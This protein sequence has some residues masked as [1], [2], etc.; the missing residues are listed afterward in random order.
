MPIPL[1]TPT[2]S[3]I[4]SYYENFTFFYRCPDVYSGSRCQSLLTTVQ[5]QVTT[6][7][8]TVITT[9]P[10]KQPTT[11]GEV[12]TVRGAPT[13][14][15]AP[16]TGGITTAELVTTSEGVTTVETARTTSQPGTSEAM[17]TSEVANSSVAQTNKV[18]SQGV[19]QTGITSQ[20]VTKEEE[21]YT[22][23]STEEPDAGLELWQIVA[24]ILGG[25]IF[26]FLLLGCCFILAVSY[27]G[28]QEKKYRN[29]NNYPV[30]ADPRNM[31]ARD[32]ISGRGHSSYYH[33]Y[34]DDDFESYD[35]VSVQGGGEDTLQADSR[36][37]QQDRVISL[38]S[39]LNE[40]MRNR[41]SVHGRGAEAEG[42]RSH[43]VRPYMASGNE[44][45]RSHQTVMKRDTLLSLAGPEMSIAVSFVHCAVGT[46]SSCMY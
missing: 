4:K 42:Q 38:L 3:L 29:R 1:Q 9:Q 12:T 30:L 15:K 14:G 31:V 21:E 24:I 32:E 18:T 25:A 8:E 46:D 23:V 41:A 19:T 6:Q 35:D 44:E 27:G 37:G 28:K 22:T 2:D 7:G 26:I 43:F 40:H 45:V 39:E 20:E 5:S 17:V 10:A 36:L 13:T 16:T 34:S 11:S 33:D